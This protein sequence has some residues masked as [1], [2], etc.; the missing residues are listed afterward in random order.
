MKS[1]KIGIIASLLI[2]GLAVP[3]LSIPK[4]N[5]FHQSA[6][7]QPTGL[8][9]GSYND[10][11]FFPFSTAPT[12]AAAREGSTVNFNVQL[13]T[14]GTPGQRNITVGVKLD[15]MNSWQNASSATLPLQPNQ[16]TFVAVGVS[17][18]AVSGFYTSLNLALHQWEVRI[19]NGPANTTITP[20]MDCPSRGVTS[21]SCVSLVN[22]IPFAVYSNV[23]ADGVTAKLKAAPEIASLTT[24]LGGLNQLPPGTARASSEL[25]Q[26]SAELNQGEYSYKQGDFSSAKTHYTNAEN[27]A[28]SAASDLSSQGGGAD[29]AAFWQMILNGTGVLLVGVGVVLAAFGSWM[30]LRKRSKA[31]TQKTA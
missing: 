7:A 5:A 2:L 14:S 9:L 30:Y 8:F 20:S 31:G 13:V 21:S 10:P 3:A 28:S 4:A 23:Q 1:K 11:F 27:L 16:L 15:W 19:W 18:P 29:S 24:I 22:P 6:S 25:S 26:A 17:I 12:L